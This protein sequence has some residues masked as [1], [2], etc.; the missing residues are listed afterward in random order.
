M[1][2]ADWATHSLLAESHFY[3]AV[4]SQK[5]SY[6][7]LDSYMRLAFLLSLRLS[8]TFRD[9]DLQYLISSNSTQK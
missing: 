4:V 1:K 3:L 9:R 6:Y 7:V 5:I 8:Y 2:H